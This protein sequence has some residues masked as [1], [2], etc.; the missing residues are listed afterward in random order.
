MCAFQRSSGLVVI[1]RVARLSHID[2]R[3]MFGTAWARHGV[4]TGRLGPRRA[5][6]ATRRLRPADFHRRLPGFGGPQLRL[7]SASVLDYSFARHTTVDKAPADSHEALRMRVC[8]RGRG[9]LNQASH[10]VP[11]MA[12]TAVHCSNTA[13]HLFG[14]VR[15]RR[16]SPAM[17]RDVQRLCSN[18]VRRLRVHVRLQWPS[19]DL[20]SP[21]A[22]I[23]LAAGAFIGEDGHP[24][25]DKPCCC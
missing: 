9:K 12:A 14:A 18:L 20:T 10:D 7:A 4:P 8:G 15:V 13:V 16:C 25:F 23:Q 19:V 11:G 6:T 5:A 21:V 2:A 24:G 1:R 3:L 22:A 17:I